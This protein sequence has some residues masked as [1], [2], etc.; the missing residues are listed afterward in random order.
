MHNFARRLVV[1]TTV[2]EYQPSI[3]LPFYFS[4]FS[5][6]GHQLFVSSLCSEAKKYER[7]QIEPI[8]MT[9]DTIIRLIYSVLISSTFTNYKSIVII[10]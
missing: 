7:N 6:W 10:H 5:D 8:M 9:V 1:L 4:F 3:L 2:C